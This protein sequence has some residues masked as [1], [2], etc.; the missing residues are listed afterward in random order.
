MNFQLFLSA[1]DVVKPWRRAAIKYFI[2]GT[3]L[4]LCASCWPGLTQGT[5]VWPRGPI[6]R[7]IDEP[8]TVRITGQRRPNR[9]TFGR[10]SANR[11]YRMSTYDN[12]VLIC[13]TA[14]ATLNHQ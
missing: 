10:S 14:V 5:Q 8:P 9:G 12:D 1:K 6:K 2:K 4:L 13:S 11:D 3:G 7:V